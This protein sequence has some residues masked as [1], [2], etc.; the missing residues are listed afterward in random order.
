MQ[1]GHWVVSAT[2]TAIISLRDDKSQAKRMGQVARD[3]VVQHFDR[4]IQAQ[5]FLAL[6]RELSAEPSA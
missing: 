6:V 1:Y 5:E 4:R 3:Y 2:A